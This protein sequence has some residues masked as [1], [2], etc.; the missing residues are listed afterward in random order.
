MY[1]WHTLIFCAL[2]KNIPKSLPISIIYINF[3]L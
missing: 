2:I 1:L 3:A